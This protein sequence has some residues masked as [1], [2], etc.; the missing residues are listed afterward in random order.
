[1]SSAITR[2]TPQTC[3]PFISCFVIDML[4][5]MEHRQPKTKRLGYRRGT[6]PQRYITLVVKYLSEYLQ[7]DNIKFTVLARD[8][9]YD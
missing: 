8:S 7:L 4:C 5:T 1:M 9:L 6:E 2:A 3:A